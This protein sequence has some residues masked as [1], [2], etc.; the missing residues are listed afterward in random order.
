ML[1][2]MLTQDTSATSETQCAQAP[3]NEQDTICSEC[4]STTSKFFWFEQKL[5]NLS[6]LTIEPE[7]MTAI[8][9]Q[10]EEPC[11]DR[12]DSSNP[13]TLDLRSLILM[14]NEF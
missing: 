5:N 7:D 12:K 9:L 4:A 13:N 14:H 3:T 10:P 1:Y 11:N 8:A 2:P 6:M